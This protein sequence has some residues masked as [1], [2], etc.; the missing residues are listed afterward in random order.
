MSRDELKKSKRRRAGT[1]AGTLDRRSF[2]AGVAGVACAAAARPAEALSGAVDTELNLARVARPS[3]FTTSSENKISALNDGYLPTD[4]YDRTHGV[5]ALRPEF[6]VPG[7][8]PRW[9]QY[10]WPVPVAIDKMDVYWAID[11]PR[12]AGYP[13]SQAG[14]VAAPASYRVLYWNGTD[15]VPVTNAHGLGVAADQFN[16]TT[17]DA[18]RTAKL[19]LEVVPN[20]EHAAGIMEWM[21]Y[22]AGPAPLLAPAV[23]AGID[24]SVVLGGQTYLAA[25]AVWLQD[26]PGNVVRWGKASG[27][28]TVSFAKAN[29]PATT[30]TFSV[31]GD[32]MLKLSASSR[33]APAQSTLN[34]HVE[35]APPTERLNVVYTKRYSID[36]PL[37][38]ARARTLIVDWIPHCITYCERTDIVANRGD[39][40]IDNFI[41]AG[42]ALRGE[43]HAHH[44]GY[45]FSNAWVHQTVESMCIALMVDP[46]GDAEMI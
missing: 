42:K 25:K 38:N 12:A 2:L 5:Y 45:V 3:S 26:E 40:G 1:S 41:E 35:E 46:Q 22:N 23:D 17:F 13:G 33:N 28:G 8:E 34:V 4:S 18:V 31:P 19:R 7:R 24:R 11:R 39:G 36:S 9:V 21:V 27:P 20:G 10:E 37:W 14:R 32:Y 44:K 6:G 15:F 30:A 29:S 16:T 43:P